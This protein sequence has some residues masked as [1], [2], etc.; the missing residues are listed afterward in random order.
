[1]KVQ[2]QT[3][4]DFILPPRCPICAER[5]FEDGHFCARCWAGFSLITEPIC[6]LCGMPF[7]YEVDDGSVCGSCLDCQPDFDRARSVFCYEGKGRSLVLALKNNRSFVGFSALAK[8]MLLS[9]SYFPEI[10][11]IIPVPLHPAR[12]LTRRFNQS[13]LIADAYAVAGQDRKHV[14]HNLLKRIQNTPSQGKLSPNKRRANVQ[15]A[16]HIND[17]AAG[18]IKNKSVLIVDDVYTTGATL[19][20]CAKITFEF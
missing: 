2:F 16:F 1:M 11:I 3:L 4:I 5:V 6:D 19:G 20:A 17:K 9:R 18:K 7:D 10:D 13:N 15:K 14:E 12:M 8:L